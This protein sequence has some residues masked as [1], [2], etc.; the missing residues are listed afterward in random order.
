MSTT[1]VPTSKRAGSADAAT[2]R[3]K[4]ASVTVAMNAS[5]LAPLIAKG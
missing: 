4:R 2:G 5:L 3:A 1:E